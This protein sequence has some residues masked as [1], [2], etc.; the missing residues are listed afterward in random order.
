[1]RN[2]EAVIKRVEQPEMDQ[3]TTMY[4]AEA[5]QFIETRKEEP[6]F[7]FLSHNMPHVPLGVSDRLRGKSKAGLYGDVIEEVDLS[8]G[9]VMQKLKSLG[10]DENTLIV[11]L[12]DNGPWIEKCIGEDAGHADPLRGAKMKSWEGGPRVP[13]IMRWPGKI[14]AGKTCDQITTAMDFLTTFA[15]RMT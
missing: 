8:L 15:Q 4:T 10:L 12:S 5:L 14:S 2:H 11:F 3:L 6:F 1:M 9:Q 13:C 7:L